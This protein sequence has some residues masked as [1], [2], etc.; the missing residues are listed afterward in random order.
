MSVD[1]DILSPPPTVHLRCVLGS[2]LT[3]GWAGPMTSFPFLFLLPGAPRVGIC[4]FASRADH[5]GTPW[6]VHVALDKSNPRLHPHCCF[7]DGIGELGS[8]LK[9]KTLRTLTYFYVAF[10]P[11]EV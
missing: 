3:R 5:T 7:R 11:E 6:V 4:H 10:E 1:S 2:E 9:V 8:G